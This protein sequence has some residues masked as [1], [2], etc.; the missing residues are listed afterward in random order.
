MFFRKQRSH[1][2]AVGPLHLML[3]SK[4][5]QGYLCDFPQITLFSNFKAL[6]IVNVA[7]DNHDFIPAAAA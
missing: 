1:S 3:A 2:A 5:F 7:L 6:R 4:I